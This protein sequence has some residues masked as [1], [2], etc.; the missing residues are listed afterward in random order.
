M[1]KSQKNIKFGR[2]LFESKWLETKEIKAENKQT[3][4]KNQANNS[5]M[6]QT[7]QKATNASP[8]LQLH[9]VIVQQK[10]TPVPSTPLETVFI[11]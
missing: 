5:R 7:E 9:L 2:C 10:M 6:Q 8:S 1:W 4:K 11:M 3:N